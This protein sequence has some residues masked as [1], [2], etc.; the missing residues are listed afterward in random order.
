MTQVIQIDG[1]PGVGKTTT[2]MDK[3]SEAV[4]E[5]LTAA[6]FWFLTFTRSGR[7]EAAADLPP[8]PEPEE[9]NGTPDKRVRTLHSLALRL[10]SRAGIVEWGD[11]SDDQNPILTHNQNREDGDPYAE[12]CDRQGMRYDPDAADSQKLLSGEEPTD[13]VGNRFFALNDFLRQTCKPADQWHAAPIE[14]PMTASRVQSLVWEWDRFKREAWPYRLFEHGDYV[15]EVIDDRQAPAGKLLLIDEFQDFAPLEYQAFKLWRDRGAFEDIYIA[16]D[17]NQS[18]YSF[19]GGTP[20]YFENTEVYDRITLKESR[21]CR[22]EIARF[23]R[24]VLASHPDTDP[25]GFSGRKSGGTVEHR[26]IH[27]PEELRDA[28]IEAAER[29]ASTGGVMLLTRTRYQLG[30]LL[31]D[32]RKVGVPFNV[33]GTHPGVW[34]G[35]LPKFLT[36]LKNWQSA[37]E[38]FAL[39]NVRTTAMHL[40][41]SQ[42]RVDR[43]HGNTGGLSSREAVAPVFEGYDTAGEILNDLLIP[44]WQR[45]ILRNAVDAPAYLEPADVRAGTI[46]AA[47]GLE[48]PAVFL[49]AATSERMAKRYQRDARLAAEEH[50]AYYVAATRASEELQL[51]H[52]YFDGPTTPPVERARRNRQVAA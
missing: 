28:V 18:I 7:A 10:A 22:A 41:D 29:H 40:P 19:R 37:G 15:R 16:G 27:T 33:L 49:F 36:A 44:D 12:F 47:K 38:A 20:Y 9:G 8:V 5:G 6:D 2:L 11:P 39:A 25:R 26:P 48:A 13:Y 50:R 21:R 17:P 31:T 4:A 42:M 23:A 35:N 24:D 46:H 30:T 51:V 52:G 34:R 3:L 1:A 32:F 45:D 14:L 43:L